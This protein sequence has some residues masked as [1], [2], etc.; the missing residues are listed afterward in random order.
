MLYHI[1]V[2][3]L[4]FTKRGDWKLFCSPAS[5]L[6]I[7]KSSTFAVLWQFSWLWPIKGVLRQCHLETQRVYFY[8]F[9][10]PY[11]ERCC[12]NF[13]SSI[14]LSFNELVKSKFLIPSMGYYH[15]RVTVTINESL[16]YVLYLGVILKSNRNH[17]AIHSLIHYCSQIYE[18][19]G[20][21][22]PTFDE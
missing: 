5:G 18:L 12:R 16:V 4:G 8:E 11:L 20:S 7:L 2:I 13:I 17:L 19:V 1:L 10:S 22:L 21:R 6:R 15:Q 3:H 9:V 14:P